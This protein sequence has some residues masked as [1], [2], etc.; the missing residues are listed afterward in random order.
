M[1]KNISGTGMDT[2]VIGRMFVPGVAEPD[3]PKITAIVVLDVTEESHGNAVGIGLADFTTERLVSK[4]DW[5]ATYMNS[6]TSGTG[7]LLRGRLPSVLPNDRAAIATAMRMVGQPDASKIRLARIK[8]TLEAA[9]VE[10]SP[11][12]L[13]HTAAAQVEWTSP[14]KPLQFDAAGRLI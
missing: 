14:A 10:F 5:H 9:H 8:N 13:E 12:L 4:I 6:Y 1:G 3:R 2:N 11:S 7:G